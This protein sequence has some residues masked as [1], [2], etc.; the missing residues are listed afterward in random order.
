MRFIKLLF[1]SVCSFAILIFLLSLLLPS[2]AVVERSGVID[3]PIATVYKEINDLRGWPRWNPWTAAAPQEITYS[4]PATG[5]GA[6]YTWSGIQME[7][8]IS[9]KVTITDSDLHKGVHYRMDF[10]AM[11]PVIAGIELKPSADGNGTAIM[12]H[13]ETHLGWMP[14]WKFR[15]FLAD[16]LMGTQLEDGLTRLKNICEG[17]AAN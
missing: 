7:K 9:G 1:I 17:A 2:R 12:W 6:Y 13:L 8:R 11:K 3:A 5:T 15:G 10:N 14:W 16:R 4:S